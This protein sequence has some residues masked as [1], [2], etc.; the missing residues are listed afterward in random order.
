MSAPLRI[1]ASATASLPWRQERWRAVCPSSAA[2]LTSAPCPSRKSAA[3]AWPLRQAARRG[4][5]PSGLIQFTS[6]ETRG[7]RADILSALVGTVLVDRRERFAR[8]S[9]RFLPTIH[10]SSTTYH[11]CETVDEVSLSQKRFHASTAGGV[12]YTSITIIIVRR[13]ASDAINTA[14]LNR[15]DTPAVLLCQGTGECVCRLGRCVYAL[16]NPRQIGLPVPICTS[17]SH[18]STRPP[19][20]AAH[21][22]LSL[23]LC[24]AAKRRR[25]FVFSKGE[26]LGLAKDLRTNASL[27][28]HRRYP[29]WK[30]RPRH[31][32]QRRGR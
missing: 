9:R 30:C 18:S 27:E 19:F 4:V 23:N 3:G 15:H 12:C 22:K 20:A 26:Y 13:E 7:K 17:D 16:K 11:T 6:D 28:K 29:I 24:H 2:R 25:L 5:S 10:T 31:G 21:R 32:S 14:V 8:G 1:K